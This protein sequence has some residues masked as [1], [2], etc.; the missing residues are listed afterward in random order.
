[1]QFILGLIV[2]IV[3]ATIGFSGLAQ[4]AD[5]GVNVIQETVKENVR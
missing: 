3:V 4:W 2:G 1:M 5:R